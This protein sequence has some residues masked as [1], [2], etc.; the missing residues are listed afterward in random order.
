M[1]HPE[2][3]ASL[4]REVEWPRVAVTIRQI[5]RLLQPME[6]EDMVLEVVVV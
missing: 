1:D 4:C 6:E 5:K 2:A 3:E